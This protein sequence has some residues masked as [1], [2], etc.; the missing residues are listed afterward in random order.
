VIPAI[1]ATRPGPAAGRVLALLLLPVLLL[2]VFLGT[3]LSAA[4]GTR[5]LSAA[6]STS[7][8]GQR[9]RF[10]AAAQA[11]IDATVARIRTADAG[12][13]VSLRDLPCAAS[14]TIGT[15][16]GLGY[17]VRIAY[18]SG[19]PLA[20]ATLI[21]C[22]PQGLVDRPAYAQL[23]SVSRGGTPPGAPGTTA[24]ATYAFRSAG[25]PPGGLLR[26]AAP[27]AALCLGTDSGAQSAPSDH[28]VLA[29][30][31][32]ASAGQRWQYT[33]QFQLRGAATRLCLRGGSAPDAAVVL[34]ACTSAAL[35]RWQLTGASNLRLAAATSPTSG[36]LTTADAPAVAGVEVV[37]GTCS[38]GGDV[39]AGVGA[40]IIALRFRP[41]PGVGS[42]AAGSARQ[43]LVNAGTGDCLSVAGG[44][45]SAGVVVESPCVSAA[46]DA[47]P[48]WS[49]RFGFLA[50]LRPEVGQYRTTA[51]AGTYCLQ[52]GTND[53]PPV[54][55]T[56]VVA[57]PC[58]D[59]ERFQQWTA[60][61][62]SSS[63]GTRYTIAGP[64][65]LCLTLR[66]APPP[67][68]L[69][70][71]AVAG[72]DGSLEQK[73]NAPPLSAATADLAGTGVGG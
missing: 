70:R 33:P 64:S 20:P 27:D 10:L 62:Q 67:G 53:R 12:P 69:H 13:S 18:Y 71:A 68:D 21:A 40:G 1:P 3:A 46:E 59:G 61:A 24:R 6:A 55:G 37:L 44:D 58:N 50:G 9:L 38:S 36:C 2:C 73:W 41:E 35:E 49:Q 28:L 11:G 47:V 32:P 65:G 72:C 45:V 51:P 56:A 5:A 52:A 42:G 31:Q 15:A 57:A 29:D 30:C 14:G 66:P 23:T 25:R 22:S 26:L 17:D 60:S 39:G 34:A 19:A 8:D 4:I 43:N 16:S 48:P 7:A 63:P 54:D